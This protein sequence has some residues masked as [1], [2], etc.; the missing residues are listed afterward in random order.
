MNKKISALSSRVPNLTDLLYIGDPSNGWGYKATAAELAAIITVNDLKAPTANVSFG[1]YGLSA[2][3]FQADLTP[4]QTTGVGRFTWNDVDGTMDLGLKGGNV[5]LQL[6]QELVKRIVNKTTGNINLLESNYQVVKIS[7]ATGQRMSVD[8]AQGNSDLNSATTLG[9]VTENINNNQEGFITTS[10]EVHNINT[11]GS[12][13]GETWVDGDVLYLSP[14]VA[15]QLTK[16]K[17]VAPQHM[18]IVGYV[19]YAHAVNGKL[20]VKVDNGYELDELHN[21]LIS[22]ATSGQLLQYNGTVWTNW[23]PTYQGALS[24]TGI[25]KSTAGTISYL[26]DNS[27][28]WNS[29]YTFTS[30]FPSQTGN[31]GK[32]LTTNGTALSWATVAGGTDFYTT[33]GTLTSNR[34]VSLSTFSLT[35]AGTTSSR[36]FANGNAGIGTTTDAGYKLDVNGTGRIQGELTI[37]NTSIGRITGGTINNSRPTLY[38][39]AGQSGA[40]NGG[41]VFYGGFNGTDGTVAMNIFS[42]GTTDDKNAV[43]YGPVTE[44]MITSSTARFIAKSKPLSA[45]ATNLDDGFLLYTDGTYSYSNGKIWSAFVIGNIDGSALPSSSSAAKYSVSIGYQQHPLVNGWA[46]SMLM[47]ARN[48]AGSLTE[49]MRVQGRTSAVAIGTSQSDA[50]AKLEV[51]STTQGF[52]PPRMTGA[53]AEA[54]TTPAAGLLVYANAGTGTTITSVGWWGYNGTTWVRL[55]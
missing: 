34:T 29:A 36:F 33:D 39:N 37:Q 27:T 2:G 48:E 42:N 46:S 3:Y 51:A 21:V 9:V 31:S 7:G 17:P 44:A 54:I 35:F 15:G 49:V 19:E 26:T 52:L 41:H 47:M 8:L 18:V 23:T 30:A 25:V 22:S 13:Q 10:G 12:L 50:S 55:N 32:Y 53:Q 28:N 45:N 4:T 5:T 6:G 38:K 11:T 14:T 40:W 1:E 20:F 16:V 24:G 43:A